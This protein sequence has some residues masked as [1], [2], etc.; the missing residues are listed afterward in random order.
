MK[1]Y[2]S[3]I[4]AV[5][6]PLSCTKH[7]S[8]FEG[9]NSFYGGDALSHGM[10]VLGDRLENPYVTS[11]V[12]R[13]FEALYPTKS[14]ASLNSTNLYV[15]F[16]PENNDEYQLLKASGVE[17]LD[18][19]LDYE[20]V[21]E[22]DY[23]HDPALGDDAITWQYAVVPV[24]F[25]FPDVR[26]EIIDECFI[27]ENSPSAKADADVDWEAV[28]RESFIM[29]GNENL[30]QEES[31]TKASKTNPSGRIT[32]VDEKA[33]GGQPFGLAG[34]KVSCNV[35]V[36]FSHTYTDRDGYYTIPKKFSSKPR[37]RIIFSNEKGFNIGFNL[38]L[39][40]ASVSTL[41]KAPASGISYTVTRN[42][43][44]QLY[45]RAVVNNAAYEYYSRCGES[46]MGIAAPPGDLRIWIFKGLTASS[47]IM[48]HHGAIIDNALLRSY[49]GSY[50][51][52]IKLFLPDIT[53]G[54]KDSDSYSE[55]YDS[56]VHEL[57]HA[58]HFSQVG[59]KYWD[60]YIFYIAS[61][62]LKTGGKTYG[63]GSGDYAGHC[64]VGEMWAYYVESMLHKERYG[65][66]IPAYGT[67]FW[68]YPQIFR[69]LEE[70]GLSRKEIFAAM[71]SDVSGKQALQD[72]LTAL[73]PRK[74]T[75]V[76]QVFNRYRQ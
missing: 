53:I 21:T 12:R 51:S 30:L 46:D 74:R 56:V 16:L 59:K 62:Y 33:N 39:I 52:L 32:I 64:E 70:R 76:E 25:D 69:Y 66:Q 50:A 18:H 4:F 28:E 49:L 65:G 6:L 7:G 36:K 15:R 48:G 63:D 23:Y 9:D 11:T 17:M 41:G 27:A 38:I 37:Y 1:K 22:G 55:I 71:T 44:E 61:T 29:T 72:K 40:P 60:Q 10:I 19:P 47:A 57:S 20:V 68:F 42:S 26:Y 31:A 73:Y 34:V 3:F 58:S 13:A 67:S 2:L 24:G 45:R 54:T 8:G 14:S 75:M 43:D 5:L 35:F